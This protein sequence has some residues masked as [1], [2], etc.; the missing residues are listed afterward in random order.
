MDLGMLVG[1]AAVFVAALAGV[2]G[3]WMERE[4]DNPP[5]FALLFS[6][7]ILF[8]SSIEVVR[9]VYTSWTDSAT[10]EK[11]ASVLEQLAEISERSGDPALASFVGNELAR[12]SPKMVKRLEKRAA[13]NGRDPAA[14][15][16][17]AAEGRQ[18]NPGA[19]AKAKAGTGEGAGAEEGEAP[20]EGKAGKAGGE[21]KAGKAGPGEPDG[22][23]EPGEGGATE[24][25]AEKAGGGAGGGEGKA[26]KAGGAPAE[27]KTGKGK[28]G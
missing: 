6:T 4:R 2:L 3:V 18:V 17:K 12:S 9:T 26:G 22:G 10:Q 25:K 16:R 20:P 28:A 11:M 8:A 14:V 5:W 24:G 1:L 27:G 19:P 7:L 15:R 23:A 21:G 13:A